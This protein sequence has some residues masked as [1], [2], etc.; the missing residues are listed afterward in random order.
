[1][2]RPKVPLIARDEVL[3]I[4]L[5]IIDEEGLEALSIRRLAEELNVNGASLY[6]HFANK[7]AIVSG[8]AELAVARTPIMVRRMT[9]GDWRDWVASGA[10]QLRDALLAHPHLAP[11]IVRRRSMGM[12]RQR[13]DKVTGRLVD[14]GVPVEI[15]VPIFDSLERFVIGWAIRASNAVEPGGQPDSEVCPHLDV[16]E[17]AAFADADL[18]FDVVVRGIIDSIEHAYRVSPARRS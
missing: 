15:V 18:L 14:A 5:H 3:E 10:R 12:A 2:G 1:M 6:H 4:A 8:A 17:A 7:D 11:V 9:N 13:L 16:A